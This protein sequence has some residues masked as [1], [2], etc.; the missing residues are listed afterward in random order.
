MITPDV[1]KKA[2]EY[3][4]EKD[5]VLAEVIKKSPP[6]EWKIG[7]NY[8]VSLSGSI[9]SQQLSMKAADTI[10]TR[11]QKLFKNERINPED[12]LLL[13]DETIR[14]CGIS[15]SKI[16]YIKD[17]ARKTLESGIIFEQFDQM[18]EQE[19]ID[20]LVK[21]KGVGVWTAQMFI[22]FTMGREDIFSYGDLGLRR[23]IEKLY[24]LKKEPTQKQA[25]KIASKWKPYRTI[26]CRYLWKSLEM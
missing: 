24:K 15:Y 4:L 7:G 23:A 6:L 19:I 17:L 9:I 26:A 8:F 25:E 12:V 11:F 3:L 18:T 16:T 21:V 20:E 2:R 14:N 13:S 10:Y 5:P 22:M 1:E